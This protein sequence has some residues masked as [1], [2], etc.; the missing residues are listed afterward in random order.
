[1]GNASSVAITCVSHS[2][3]DVQSHES[4]AQLACQCAVL[5]TSQQM[6]VFQVNIDHAFGE[7]PIYDSSKVLNQLSLTFE[8]CVR[9]LRRMC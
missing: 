3:L 5:V 2:Q 4:H 7:N 9:L 8:Y 6:H 1:M